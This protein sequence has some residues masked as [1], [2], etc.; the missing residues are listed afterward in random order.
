WKIGEYDG[1]PTG[2]LNADKCLRMPPS[3]K[4]M[5]PWKP[6]TF[7]VGSSALNE[8]PMALFQTVNNPVTIKF[9]LKSAPGAATLR[10]ATT[11]SYNGARPQAKINSFT[12]KAPAAPAKID[13]RGVTRGAYRGHGEV[14]DV[15]IPAGTLVAGDNTITITSI[16]GS[17]GTTFLNPNFVSTIS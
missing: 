16:S 15:S 10:I 5:S 8:F 17:S 13:S 14:Y 3:D 12:A 4:R 9:N 6:A 1:Q 7:T 2:F 11:L